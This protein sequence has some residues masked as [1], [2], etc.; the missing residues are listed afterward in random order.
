MEKYASLILSLALFAAPQAVRAQFVTRPIEPLVF[1]APAAASAPSALPAALSIQAPSL[2]AGASAAPT[3]LRV[4]AAV[5]SARIAAPAM[6]IARAA[7]AD[8]PQVS[9]PQNLLP[10]GFDGAAAKPADAVFP[11]PR[12][13]DE[14]GL[15]TEKPRLTAANIRAAYRVGI[16]PWTDLGETAGWYSPEQRGVL[17]FSELHVSK[18]LERFRRKSGLRATFNTAFDRVIR[19]C[20]LADRGEETWISEKFIQAYSILHA[21]GHAHSVEVWSGDKLVGGLYGVF[22]DGVFNGES[23]F[24]A[25]PN[26]GKI[27]LLALADRLTSKGIA[28]MDLQMVT[29]I[30]ASFGAKY[31]PR[32]EYLKRLEEAHKAA[33]DAF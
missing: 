19:A 28:W 5:R 2:A 25:A 17:D 11:D 1:G 10:G 9:L 20:A 23:M 15:V 21:E 3:A 8:G 4:D 26:A 24:H 18:S 12:S 6:S 14:E 32:D 33:P 30:M 13:A 22:L 7:P 31:I 29:D 16:F 27:A